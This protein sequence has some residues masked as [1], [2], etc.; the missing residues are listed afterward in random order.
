MTSDILT[1]KINFGQDLNDKI[2]NLEQIQCM[3][4]LTNWQNSR[5]LEQGVW[6]KCCGEFLSY[7]KS[8]FIIS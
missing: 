7:I 4:I 3:T 6:H 8:C 5:P 1:C 2:D